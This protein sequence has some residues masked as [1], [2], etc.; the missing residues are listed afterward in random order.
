MAESKKF[1]YSIRELVTLMLKD[2]NIHEGNWI[3]TAKFSLSVIN[4]GLSPDSSDVAPAGLSK[5][6]GIGIENVID[7]LPFSVDASV[8][9]P[10]KTKSQSK[11]ILKKHEDS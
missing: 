7:P 11:K 4:I 1:D 8:V 2:Q 9:N 5:I 10:K 6:D 3:L